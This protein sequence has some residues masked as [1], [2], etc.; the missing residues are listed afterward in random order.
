MIAILADIHSNLEALQAVLADMQA[1]GIEQFVCLGDV[2]GYGPSP[3]ECLE[4]VRPS[5]L[6]LMG[7]H[8]QT[9]LLET[10]DLP[11]RSIQILRWTFSEIFSEE[12]EKEAN[13]D[14]WFQLEKMA[15][16]EQYRSEEGVLFVHGSPTNPTHGSVHPRDVEDPELLE[17][18]FA[19]VENLCFCGHTHLPGV[20]IDGQGYLPPSTN[21]GR[22]SYTG[23]KMI[24][25]VGSIGYP[26]DR[27]HRACYV[28]YD[29]SDVQFHR[30]AYDGAG[31][32]GR[33]LKNQV[34][35]QYWVQADHM[36]RCLECGVRLKGH[37]YKFG[38][39]VACPNCAVQVKTDEL[40][41]EDFASD[42]ELPVVTDAPAASEPVDAEP[43]TGATTGEVTGDESQ[44]LSPVAAPQHATVREVDELIG[45]NLSGYQILTLIGR[46]GMAK[47]YK[48]R[49]VNLDRLVAVKMLPPELTGDE[50]YVRRF[51]QEARALARFNHPN[52]VTI[53]D[54]FCA[55]GRYFLAME[56]VDGVPLSTLIRSE[57]R[58]EYRRALRLARAS[59]LGLGAAHAQNIVHRDVSPA[60]I[61]VLDGDIVKLMDFGIAVSMDRGQSEDAAAVI[62]TANYM[63][64]EQLF[65]TGIDWRCDF[66]G[67]GASL[68]Q[69]LT[70]VRPYEG[71][72][73]IQRRA[74]QGTLTPIGALVGGLPPGVI[75]LVDIM[76][77]YDKL[78]RPKSAQEVVDAIDRL[79]AA[80]P[81]AA[82]P[83]PPPAAQAPEV[84]VASRPSSRS[85]RA[86][87][88]R[89]R[90]RTG[91]VPRVPTRAVTSPVG[92]Q[93]PRKAAPPPKGGRIDCPYCGEKIRATAKICGF[94]RNELR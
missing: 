72:N 78:Q 35:A 80:P 58:I 54:F 93:V 33:I 92:R 7:D 32:R 26:K 20:F 19:L 81:P 23:R 22:I 39:E 83:P 73:M 49:Q 43:G 41:P 34:V 66:Y 82:A 3:R 51:D 16:L 1:Q 79:L 45:R 67:M 37:D 85:N 62:G 29:G 14:L 64:P 9:L 59:L 84:V 70:G 56:F 90:P 42:A 24:V 12:Y 61:M 6:T 2:I 48:A 76:M 18:E 53:H 40:P 17:R 55:D 68:Y 21:D 91:L 27:D 57:G 31:V 36:M 50:K 75:R 89:N 71:L 5:M 13:R 44:F 94:C 63:A 4:L 28:T 69:A 38:V 46:G 65:G 88:A 77:A 11:A 25:N 30:V 86:R 47:V 8:E 74:G 52:V 15:S 87:P 60:N 10:G